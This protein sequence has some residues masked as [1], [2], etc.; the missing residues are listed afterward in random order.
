MLKT[1]IISIFSYW[2]SISKS[3]KSPIIYTPYIILRII[4]TPYFQIDSVKSKLKVVTDRDVTILRYVC[5][6]LLTKGYYMDR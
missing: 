2:P 1:H 6:I 3:F 5:K 4:Y